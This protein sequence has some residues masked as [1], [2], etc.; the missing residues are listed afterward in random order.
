MQALD[1]AVRF[2]QKVKGQIFLYHRSNLPPNWDEATEEQKSFNTLAR[3]R[4]KEM[5]AQFESIISNYGNTGLNINPIHSPGDLFE[6]TEELVEQY[7][8]DL[9]VMGSEG[10]TGIKEW[11]T[12]S[13]AEKI[14]ETV[15]VPVL[16]IK[17]KIDEFPLK[18]IVFASEFE[19]AAKQAF[20]EL[21]ELVRDFD[22]TIHLLYICS[23]KE[24]VVSQEILDNMHEFKDLCPDLPCNIHT[25]AGHSVESGIQFFMK[26]TGADLLC[27]VHRPKGSFE[28][29]WTGSNSSK[30]INHLECPVLSIPVEDKELE[31][32]DS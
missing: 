9:I 23:I 8:I 13:N 31:V 7:E 12:G 14:S 27:L 24:F 30:L 4:D 26:N 5:K 25:R 10:A 1:A 18:Q 29:L 16:I 11:Y 6:N 32:K 28:K 19:E 21:I 22:T 17:N 3:K 20:L 2:A 15:D